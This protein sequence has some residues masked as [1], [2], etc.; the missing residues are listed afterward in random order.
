VAAHA[1]IR[2]AVGARL[3]L[4][5]DAIE[6]IAVPGRAPELRGRYGSDR[7]R[8]SL[9]H[10]R[11]LV[12]CAVAVDVPVGTDVE[13]VDHGSEI[14]ELVS[15]V[16]SPA[17]RSAF[18][19]L[20]A[21][22]RAERFFVLWTLKESYLK[23]LGIGLAGGADAPS[24]TEISFDVEAREIALALGSPGA[25]EE[26]GW[27]FVTMRPLGDWIVSAAVGRLEGSRVEIVSQ[28]VSSA[29]LA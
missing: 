10:T 16:L 17:E 27:R 5:A 8:L 6:L 1:L 29:S 23:A 18:R 20:P 9:S 11:G 12:A 13:R 3:G 24:L 22:A 7:I 19:R 2:F 26:A 14:D 21:G 15:V 25:E 28:P 4:Q